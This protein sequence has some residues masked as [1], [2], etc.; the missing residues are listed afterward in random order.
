MTIREHLEAIR[1]LHR[2]ATDECVNEGA[3][4]AGWAHAAAA[5]ADLD[6]ARYVIDHYVG[7]DRE[8]GDFV[9]VYVRLVRDPVRP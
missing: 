6:R 7:E 4:C 1:D 8:V 2:C 3:D 5:L 9:P